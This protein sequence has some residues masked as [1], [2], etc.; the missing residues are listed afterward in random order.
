MRYL[1]NT[2]MLFILLIISSISLT[3][4]VILLFEG[5]EKNNII[6]KNE[7]NIPL[8]ATL[9]GLYFEFDET[10]DTYVVTGALDE[11]DVVLIPDMLY[12][13]KVES[14]KGFA[15]YQ[16][17][18]IETI[19]F[20][21]NVK[22]IGES[23]FFEAKNLTYIYNMDHVEV[24]EAYAFY[25]DNSLITPLDFYDIRYIGE[26]A[27]SG[28]ENISQLSFHLNEE[29]LKELYI[30]HYAFHRTF[31]LSNE[32]VLYEKTFELTT[33]ELSNIKIEEIKIYDV[34]R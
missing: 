33:F 31:K 13:Y 2:I 10:T 29:N 16:N 32:V 19:F 22:E 8:K 7:S 28:V 25:N 30:G 15:F 24:I 6:S 18:K 3:Y 27:F 14:I 34:I 5:L 21:A 17:Q 11:V 4:S 9:N 1:T 20:G 26:S 23:A 12:G